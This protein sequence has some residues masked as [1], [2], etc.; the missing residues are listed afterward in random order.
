MEDNPPTVVLLNG[1][2]WGRSYS[3]KNLSELILEAVIALVDFFEVE[4]ER[5]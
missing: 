5:L 3:P 1:K 2:L 4:Q